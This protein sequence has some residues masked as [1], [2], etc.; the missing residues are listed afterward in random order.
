MAT[1]P[2]VPTIPTYT[3]DDDD[4]IL[5]EEISDSDTDLLPQLDLGGFD[6]SDEDDE[7]D[8]DDEFGESERNLAPHRELAQ[9]LNLGKSNLTVPTMTQRVPVQPITVPKPIVPNT[10]LT[11]AVMPPVQ[12]PPITVPRPL[13]GLTTAPPITVPQVPRPLTGLTMA[14]PITVPQVPGPLTGLTMAPPIT[15]P[16]T[17]PALNITP[18]IPPIAP[19][20]A[21]TVPHL[22]PQPAAKNIDIAAI[23]AKMP[24]IT[25]A[26]VTPPAGQVPADIND[27]LQKE[28]DESEADFEARRR[29]T[30]L[31]AGIPDYKLNNA[32]AVTAGHLMMKKSKLGVTYD[33]DV[34]SA[35]AYLAALLQR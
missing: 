17:A 7:D 9:L 6:D 12:A 16:R 2:L 29:L 13:T 32:T 33:P 34:E 30:L 19:I 21:P 35:I 25:I 28:A 11:L 8:E 31:L 1:Y 15:V 5:D 27:L 24:G 22:A 14:P 3:I 4:D 10:G 20:T 23:L 26:T 18:N